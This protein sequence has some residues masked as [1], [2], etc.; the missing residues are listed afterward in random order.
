[1]VIVPNP[2][3]YGQ[4]YELATTGGTGSGAVSYST[5]GTACSVSGTTLS[6][7]SGTGTCSVTA[8]KAGDA[9]YNPV[10]SPATPVSISKPFQTAL[11]V[12]VPNPGVYGQ[13][14][15]LTTSGG[16]GD[17]AVTYSVSG[18]ACVLLNATTLQITSGTGTCSVTATKAGDVN[19]VAATSPVTPVTIAKADQAITFAAPASP[20]TYNT[21]FAVSA[22][23]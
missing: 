6:I 4:D 18:T 19:Y 7:T 1:S 10:S 15:P 13:T 21:T 3:L 17:G 14:Y 20:A 12:N 23:S 5:S 22:S 2:G 11:T 16:S 8:S 9:N